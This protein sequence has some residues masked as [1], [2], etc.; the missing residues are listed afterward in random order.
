MEN[1]L[2]NKGRKRKHLLV[3]NIQKMNAFRSVSKG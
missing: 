2:D 1:I 3:L